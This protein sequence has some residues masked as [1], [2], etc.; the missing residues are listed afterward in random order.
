MT[1][2]LP[3]WLRKPVRDQ[4]KVQRLNRRLGRAGLHTVCREA[5]CPNIGECYARNT[6]TFLLLGPTCSR[7]CGFCNIQTGRL[8]APDPDEP[9]RV[10]EAAAEMNLRHV[11][12]TSV[13]RD[14]LP[15]GG[16]EQFLATMQAVHEALPEATIE[17]LTPDFNGDPAALDLIASGPL[18]VFNHNMET[19]H[20]LYAEARPQA[21]YAGSLAVLASMAQRRP[22]ALCKS[23]LMLGLGE[24][25][26]E[27]ATL[28]DDMRAAGV[29]AVTIGQYLR[30]RLENLP[31]RRYVEPV[32]FERWRERAIKKG[33]LHVAAGPLVRSSYLA[34][35]MVA[36]PTLLRDTQVND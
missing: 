6:A 36:G 2:R 3:P 33:F 10:A 11:V 9:R 20:R 26:G 4:E 34:D 5:R 19:V 27:V 15:L 29:N 18:H 22:D 13:T 1:G 17:V 24:T 12:I 14:D 23:G 32:E 16:A 8:R 7:T 35:E 28:L 30:P 31:V 21:D 25:D